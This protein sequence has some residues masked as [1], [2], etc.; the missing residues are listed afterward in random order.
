MAYLDYLGRLRN[1]AAVTS[2]LVA[3]GLSTILL[4]Q[5]DA[6]AAPMGVAIPLPARQH[7]GTVWHE[8]GTHW[9]DHREPWLIPAL[10]EHESCISLTHSK[11]WSSKAKLKTSREEGAGLG[12]LTRAYRADGS[13]RF[14]A[15][16]EMRDKHPALR[17]LSWRTIYD[18]PDLQIRAVVL[19]S[20][21]DYFNF[22]NT[23]EPYAFTDAAYNGGV[24]GVVS[25]M[26]LCTLTTNCNPKKW[27]DNV[28]RTCTKSKQPIYGTRSAC[29][30]N[31]HHVRDVVLNRSVRYKVEYEIYTM[32][33]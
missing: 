32:K 12:Q 27:F 13:L 22:K 1:L 23:A 26:R 19:K 31:R 17:E 14:D 24:K 10:I 16:A 11:C 6:V 25:D 5:G 4:A 21:S 28:E 30:I 9:P 7:L 29:D 3:F 20:R 33:K 8:L 15:L 18:R 2:F